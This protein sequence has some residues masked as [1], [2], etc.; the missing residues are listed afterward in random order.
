MLNLIEHGRVL[1]KVRKVSRSIERC[2]YGEERL[3]VERIVWL[4]IGCAN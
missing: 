4:K 1:S 2:R 3:E